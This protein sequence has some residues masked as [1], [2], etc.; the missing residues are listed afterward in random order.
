[1][2]LLAGW[3]GSAL[4]ILYGGVQ[5][6]VQL[7]IL[8]G[9]IEAPADMDWRGFYGHLYLWN[10]WFVIWGVLLGITAYFYTR[11]GAPGGRDPA[12]LS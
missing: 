8:T 10:P 2:L 9:V 1:M 12:R 7:L 11:T 4:L 6:G 3:A 5:I